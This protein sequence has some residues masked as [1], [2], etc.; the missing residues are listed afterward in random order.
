[1]GTA[2][3]QIAVIGD[4]LYVYDERRV[5]WLSVE[6]TVFNFGHEKKND[7]RFLEYVGDIISTG[8]I[9]PFNG[10]IVYV[11]VKTNDAV[12]VAKNFEIYIDE[13]A[14]PNTSPTDLTQISTDGSVRTD[15]ATQSFISSTHNI[16]VN[17]GQSLRIR[18]SGGGPPVANPVVLLWV[19]WRK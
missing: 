2:T 6:S 7:D 11:S 19:K 12:G 16:D 10:T 17:K 1:M 18:V 3:G 9:V 15:A 8:A 14:Q 5:K 13:V 4:Q